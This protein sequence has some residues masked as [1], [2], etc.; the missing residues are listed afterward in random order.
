MNHKKGF[1]L[2]ELLAVVIILSILTAI[3]VPQYTKAIKRAE[4]AN[5]LI[6][7]KAVFEAARRYRATHGTWPESFVGLDTK[8]LLNDGSTNTSGA[9]E[10]SFSS[11]MVRA[12]RVGEDGAPSPY[13][14]TARYKPAQSHSEEYTCTYATGLDRYK[15]LCESLCASDFNTARTCNINSTSTPAAS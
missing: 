12:S 2:T 7:L 9:F 4:A 1:T 8:L 11:N 3:A 5:T 15:D 10:Y 13:Q 6:S 14:L